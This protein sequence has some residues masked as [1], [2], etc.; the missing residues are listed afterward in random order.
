VVLR[1]NYFYIYVV[2]I[3]F[4]TLLHLMYAVLLESAEHLFTV[5]TSNMYVSS[6]VT[7]VFTFGDIAQL[8]IQLACCRW[9]VYEIAFGL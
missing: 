8:S 1:E 9:L 6:V 4:S 7:D 5:H 2:A 3:I